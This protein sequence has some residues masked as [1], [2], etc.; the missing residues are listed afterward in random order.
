M[1]W[2]LD[3]EQTLCLIVL[4][5]GNTVV[6]SLPQQAYTSACLGQLPLLALQVRTNEGL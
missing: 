4:G 2:M 5:Q 1:F 3:V 6:Y